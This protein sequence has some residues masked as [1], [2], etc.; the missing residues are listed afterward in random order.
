MQA[1]NPE[2]VRAFG[3]FED[4]P[5]LQQ[6]PRF[7][8]LLMVLA[9]VDLSQFLRRAISEALGRHA[10]G[11]SSARALLDALRRRHAA[12]WPTRRFGMPTPSPWRRLD[13]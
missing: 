5:A 2:G 9:T 4:A 3:K 1:V 8:S 12:S 6:S 13:R 11:K 7:A 10:L